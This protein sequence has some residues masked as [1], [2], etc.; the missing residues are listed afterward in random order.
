MNL[1]FSSID[2]YI[3]FMGKN[4]RELTLHG[5]GQWT[6][7]GYTSYGDNRCLYTKRTDSPLEALQIL[8]NK[9]KQ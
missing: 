2:E 5:N 3:K 4:F 8:I 9:L 6:A 7:L 1:R